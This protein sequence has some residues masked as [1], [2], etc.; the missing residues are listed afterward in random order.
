[1][2]VR[3]SPTVA[4]GLSIQDSSLWNP[5]C[6]TWSETRSASSPAARPWR[7]CRRPRSLAA[8]SAPPAARRSAIRSTPGPWSWSENGDRPHRLIAQTAMPG[9]M[10]DRSRS[11]Q[12]VPSGTSEA[13]QFLSGW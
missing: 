5:R 10:V 13:V 6:P 12:E 4:S 7:R 1:V 9:S 8:V 3:P 2:T 11:Q